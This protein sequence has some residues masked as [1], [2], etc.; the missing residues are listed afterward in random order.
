[1]EKMQ[2]KGKELNILLAGLYAYKR[3]L[4][5]NIRETQQSGE[6]EGNGDQQL[7]IAGM[8]EQLLSVNG[9][10]IRIEGKIF[11]QRKR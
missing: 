11:P 5:E 3:E 8:G 6:Y 2:F 10:R 1:M 4:E 7:A 9:L